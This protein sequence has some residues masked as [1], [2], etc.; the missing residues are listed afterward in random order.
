MTQLSDAALQNFIVQGYHLVQP[1]APADLHRQLH[2]QVDRLLAKEGNP[3]NDLLER[4]PLLQQLLADPAVDAALTGILGPNYALNRH[5]HCHDLQPGSQAQAWHKD[6]PLGGNMRYHRTR[7][8]LL[9][10]YPHAVEPD[11]G[12]TALV[13]GTQYYMDDPDSN[14]EGLALSCK[15]GTAVI[16]H[17]EVWHRATANRSNQ[18]RY[19]LKFLF[20]R[21]QEN[22]PEQRSQWQPSGRHAGL[23]RTLWRWY[24]GQSRQAP[25]E[26]SV[27][28]LRAAQQSPDESTRL[29]AIYQLGALGNEG[30]AV[31][32]AALKAESA[33]SWKANLERGD[34]TNPS[35]LESPYGLARAGAAAVPALIEALQDSD[36]WV[37]AGAASALG[38]MGPAAREAAPILAASL[39]DNNEWVCRNAADALGNIGQA[40][41]VAV[42]ALAQALEDDRAMTPWSLSDAPLRENAVMALAKWGAPKAAQPALQKARLEGNEYIRSWAGWALDRR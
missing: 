17:Y 39:H 28:Q 13:P 40:V 21:T 14:V 2:H 24:G 27:Q 33:R 6:Y 25:P 1:Q 29:D 11:M 22:R 4:V 16:T 7:Y 23:Y 15:A 36:W 31:L 26:Q 18:T 32:M 34:F 30:V 41:A 37:R 19:M 42:P 12:P 8:A 9:L 38:C 20:A 10:Y 5:C 3:G 35:Q